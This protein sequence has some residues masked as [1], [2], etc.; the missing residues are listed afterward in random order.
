MLKAA[1]LAGQE[2]HQK[3]IKEAD[4]RTRQEKAH[5]TRAQTKLRQDEEAKAL[6]VAA[7][8]YLMNTQ[9]VGMLY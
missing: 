8:E 1:L 2:R 6:I 9:L 3:V 7:G 4:T 5:A